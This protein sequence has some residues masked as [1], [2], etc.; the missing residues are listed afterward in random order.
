M[1][2]FKCDKLMEFKRNIS[3]N[4]N[5]VDGWQCQ[6]GEIYFKSEQVQKVLMVNQLKKSKIKAKLGRIKSN[7]IL[8]IPKDVEKVLGLKEGEEVIVK[9]DDKGL[10]II[11]A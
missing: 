11:P 6:C 5:F 7:L 2:C 4:K 8:R 3:F 10:K 1:K 9:I